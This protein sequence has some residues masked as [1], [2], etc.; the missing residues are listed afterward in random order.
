MECWIDGNQ[1]PLLHKSITPQL[2]PPSFKPTM[3][4][5]QGSIN[6]L[7]NNNLPLR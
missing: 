1:V 6:L 5:N 7:A 3:V 4:G 2:H